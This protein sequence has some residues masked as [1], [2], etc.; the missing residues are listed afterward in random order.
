MYLESFGNPARFAAITRRATRKKPIVAVKSGR[1]AAGARA[2]FSHTGALA[3]TE[4]GGR[5]AAGAV[6]CAAGGRP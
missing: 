2:A 4:S 1:T 6:R 3:G 5:H